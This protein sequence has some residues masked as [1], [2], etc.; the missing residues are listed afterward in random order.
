VL[1]IDLIGSDFE[2]EIAASKL[3][4]IIMWDEIG[5]WIPAEPF[6]VESFP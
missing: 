3:G 1:G 4:F 2:L 5:F 6:F